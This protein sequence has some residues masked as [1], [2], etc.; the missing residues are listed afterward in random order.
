MHFHK[1]IPSVRPL[2]VLIGLGLLL[3]SAGCGIYS[4]TGGQ[5]RVGVETI[6]VERFENNASLIVPS[7]AQDITEALKDRFV[8]QTNLQVVAYEGDMH[9]FGYISRY[10]VSPVA[11]QGDETAAQNRLTIGVKVTYEVEQY[12][13]DNWTKTFSQFADFS[14]TRDL[15]EVE[16]ELI[17]QILDQLTLDIFNKALSNW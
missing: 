4:L 10:D 15:S 2:A 17:E 5:T 6:S 9:F 12:P 7:L 14:A 1:A 8:S 11:I 16:D 3:F 13:D